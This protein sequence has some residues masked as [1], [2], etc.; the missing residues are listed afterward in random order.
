MRLSISAV[1]ELIR[2]VGLCFAV[3]PRLRAN[4]HLCVINVV[5]VYRR[6]ER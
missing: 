6:E 4:A 1:I 3:R 2:P 5:G